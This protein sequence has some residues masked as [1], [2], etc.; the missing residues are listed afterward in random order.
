M[1]SGFDDLKEYFVKISQSYTASGSGLGGVM[2]ASDIA[3]PSELIPHTKS[4]ETTSSGNK[5]TSCHT[6][7]ECKCV[8]ETLCV[9]LAKFDN[10]DSVSSSSIWVNG[11]NVS[12]NDSQ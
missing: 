3:S 4:T 12:N 11:S 5:E 10:N 7:S 6:S 1:R 8:Y 2:L 9:S